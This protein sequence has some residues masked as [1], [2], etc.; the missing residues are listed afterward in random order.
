MCAIGAK[1]EGTLQGG[2]YYNS[3]VRT[4]VLELATVGHLT[5]LH[6]IVSYCKSLMAASACNY[7]IQH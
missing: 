3:M 5:G 2:L 1:C 6:G 4:Y 7:D